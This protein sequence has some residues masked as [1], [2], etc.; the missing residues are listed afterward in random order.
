MKGR[1][2]K[3]LLLYAGVIY[4][5]VISLNLAVMDSTGMDVSIAWMA[6][7]SMLA[8]AAGLIIVLFPVVLLVAAAAGAGWG[9]YLYCRSPMILE[10]AL[11]AVMQFYNWLYGYIVGYNHFEMKY[12]VIFAGIYITVVAFIITLTA[13]SGRRSFLLI[14]LG[15]A[16]FSFFWFIYVEKARLYLMLYLFAALVLYAYHVY[17]RKKREWDQAGNNVESNV[18]SNWMICSAFMITVSVILV[19]LLPLNI[20]PVR[21]NWM[22]NKMVSLFPVITEW[23]ND[24]LESYGFGFNS[25]YSISA[26]GYNRK[27][28]GG[29]VQPDQA[30]M[31]TV[32]TNS[33]GNIYLRGTVK[34]MYNGSF[35]SKSSKKYSEYRSGLPL[36]V[37]KDMDPAA[38]YQETFKITPAK[39][40]TSTI[41]APYSLYEVE[42]KTGKIYIDEDSEAY[43]SRK[44]TASE[45]YTIKSIMP[46]MNEAALKNAKEERGPSERSYISLPDNISQRVRDL[47]AELTAD[48]GSNYEKAKAI[49][50]YL[51]SHYRYTLKPQR[52]PKNREFVDY[53]LFEGKEGYCTYF[54]TSMAV[55]LRAS[56][57]PCR[58]VEG[59]LS[60]Y[61]DEPIRSIKGIDAHAWV[62]AYFTGYGWIA[63]EATPQY[64]VVVY[65]KPRA[66]TKTAGEAAESHNEV[67]NTDNADL[68]RRRKPL[69]G[70]DDVQ[71][72]F[73]K[74][75]MDEKSGFGKTIKYAV[76]MLA[77]L[78]IMQMI[79][80]RFL[81][82]L[83]IRQASG[84]SYSICYLEDMIYY[85]KKAGLPM[86]PDET[87]RHF[88]KR[89]RHN[90]QEKLVE[91]ETVLELIERARYGGADLKEQER[92]ALEGFRKKLKLF[93]LARQGFIKFVL[94]TY[95]VGK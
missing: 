89:V 85:F 51:R 18:M 76:L 73:E 82:E 54:A 68:S 37:P 71:S 8:V 21:W 40:L 52:I 91:L 70:D 75:Q 6:F 41:F 62:E 50:K 15:T 69:T 90:Y 33:T 31:L 47:A 65:R 24:T 56:G 53:F 32:E 86:E 19:L 92:D 39:L 46:Y 23:R 3:E 29:P 12:S 7:Y 30:V 80:L 42:C 43:F 58:Y 13:L 64:P 57:I 44:V 61:Q 55:L 72:D 88:F 1:S 34:D 84:I 81:K 66:E 83:R 10:S 9:G 16:A 48:Y 59:F 11:D 28:P 20:S 22:N 14:L 63:F 94:M 38:A 93:A 36:P 95:L 26:A 35:W 17:K 60:Q 78:R 79:I 67:R 74:K 25:R 2:A 27:N 45:S 87:L 77:L 49:E 5:M 4:L